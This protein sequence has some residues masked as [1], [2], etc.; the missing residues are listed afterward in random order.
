MTF[1]HTD[2][3][4]KMSRTA[5][6]V[7]FVGGPFSQ[8]WQKNP[9]RA[10]L[11]EG[12]EE[13][14][15][16]NAEKFMMMGKAETFGDADALVEMMACDDPKE[17]KLMGRRVKGYD[18]DRW[19]EIAR[20]IVYRGNMAKFSQHPDLLD[21]LRQTGTRK[22]VEGAWYDKVWGVGLAWD[23]PK[24][25]DEANWQG[26]NWLGEVLMRVRADLIGA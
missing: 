18:D 20:E 1:E 11:V 4:Y 10:A 2:I 22:I 14:V 25:I 23:D 6:H 13:M 16:K 21:D 19:R 9:F 12:G 5:T 7:Y 24:I 3:R 26:T 17:L 15:F 8:W